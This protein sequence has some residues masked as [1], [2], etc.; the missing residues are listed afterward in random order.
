MCVY[1]FV[2]VCPLALRNADSGCRGRMGVLL[3]SEMTL[4]TDIFTSPALQKNTLMHLSVS[5]PDRMLLEA[6][7][8]SG[9]MKQLSQ[10]NICNIGFTF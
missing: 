5:L 4:Q 3:R 7:N 10:G 6:D 2:C 9:T 1:V 8:I